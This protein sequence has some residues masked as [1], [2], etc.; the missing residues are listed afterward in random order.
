MMLLG[1]VRLVFFG[2]FAVGAAFSMPVQ[3]VLAQPTVQSPAPAQ[4]F[5]QNRAAAKRYLAAGKFSLAISFLE[6]ARAINSS[7]FDNSY[8]LSEAY[9]QTGQLEKAHKESLY[10]LT[11]RNT[12]DVHTLL[13][14]I[15]TA[16][17]APKDAAAEYQIAARMDP[18]ED[19]IFDFGRSLLGFESDAAIK[20]FSYGV[21][22]Y[23]KSSLLLLGLGEAFDVH[24]NFD[25]AAD[26]LCQAM[27]TAPDDPRPIYFLGELPV[28]TP[29]ES[30]QIDER[31]SRFLKTHPNNAN[32]NYYL[33]RD[34][35][36]P[37]AG[38]PSE[39]DLRT[40]ERMLQTAI[41]SD[42]KLAG[43]YF[44]LGRLRERKDQEKD[45][46]VAYQQAV[47][48]DP[49]E[50]KYH[51]RLLLGYRALGETEKAKREFQALQRAQAATEAKF[52]PKAKVDTP[53]PHN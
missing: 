11:I 41:H 19:R 13:G 49:A 23:P 17:H 44:E 1:N 46:V 18:S 21:E 4:D 20:I 35:L 24:G 7:D 12:A 38:E 37:H 28:V 6:K 5:E 16:A 30:R 33:A 40:G 29:E 26:V 2:L 32:A 48:L 53:T 36:N 42:P 27:D 15:A 43:A 22:K 10:L 8:D 45:A 47:K 51:Y 50:E 52:G 9:L 25:K 39:E 14:N 31:F 34:L 3:P